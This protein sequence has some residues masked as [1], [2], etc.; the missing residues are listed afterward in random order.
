MT[1]ATSD[2]LGPEEEEL[3]VLDLG[4][5]MEAEPDAPAAP[6]EPE[7]DPDDLRTGLQRRLRT[8]LLGLPSYF[9]FNNHVAGVNATDLHS[10]NTLLGASIEGQVV[11]ALNQQRAL[12]DPDDEW[13]GYTFERQSQAFPD[14]RLVRKGAGVAPGIAMGIELKGWFLLAKEG[15]PSFRFQQAAAA[16]AE[17][18]LLC[19]V[20]WHLDNVL[21]GSPVTAEP[22]VVSAR[23]AAEYRNYYWQHMRKSETGVDKSIVSPVGAAPY[24]GK[25]DEVLDQPGYDKG[26]NFGRVARTPGM[27]D[28]FMAQSHDLE[29][30][31]IRIGDWFRFLRTHSD[32][33]D[34][35]QV[36]SQLER[37]FRRQLA[38]GSA[39]K[40]ERVAAL[41]KR[42]VEEYR[43]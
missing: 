10:L 30:L 24:P 3:Q 37:A 5:R 32:K 6:T 14:V 31:G 35:E 38:K 39:A 22:F 19:V 18:D 41:L 2:E 27:M 8:V 9:E 33:A 42:L 34:P 17:H 40:A 36:T 12:W 25:V 21:S 15:K 13:L 20:P 16:C 1:D 11:K 4:S 43:G 23:W 26:D 29:V 7:L 28:E